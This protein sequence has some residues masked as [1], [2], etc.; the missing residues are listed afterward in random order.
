MLTLLTDLS[1]DPALTKGRGDR[2]RVQQG[3][4]EV[5]HGQVQ[6][7][8]RERSAQSSKPTNKR[9]DQNFS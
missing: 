6:D 1:E 3:C 4:A 5:R 7:E 2:H 9:E 8:R